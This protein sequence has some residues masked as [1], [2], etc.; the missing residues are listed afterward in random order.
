MSDEYG[1]T[2]PAATGS[3]TVD[4]VSNVATNTILGRTTAGSGN[5]EELS[6]S[7]VR[8]LIRDASDFHVIY[9]DVLESDGTFT[10]P[11]WTSDYT[12]IEVRVTGRGTDTSNSSAGIRVRFN[13]DTGSNYFMNN[14]TAQTVWNNV[15]SMPGS[16]T[17]TDR[18]GLWLADIAL[19]G[20]GRYT[21]GFVRNVTWSSTSATGSAVTTPA[22]YYTN[23]SAAITS[24]DVFLSV[25]T[26]AAGSRLTV[27]GRK[28]P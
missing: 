11:T 25:G 12:D 23:T 21:A 16:Q 19:G 10:A 7:Q 22:A 27:R 1:Y 2:P 5:S 28:A 6:A 15:G 9:D 17:N 4:V 18:Q 3:S 13:G 24:I 8:T 14:G 26:F 20:V